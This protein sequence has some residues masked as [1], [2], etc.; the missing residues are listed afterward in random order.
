MSGLG[1]KSES[2]GTKKWKSVKGGMQGFGTP[3][4]LTEK[5]QRVRCKKPFEDWMR[6]SGSKLH[7]S[8]AQLK[9]NGLSN[10]VSLFRDDIY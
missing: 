1:P 9:K 8:A 7:I 6:V 2:G 3:T 5:N 4:V 10:P